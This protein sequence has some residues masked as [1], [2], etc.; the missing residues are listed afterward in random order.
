M[1]DAQLEFHWLRAI[2]KRGK[3]GLPE[4][5]GEGDVPQ[6]VRSFGVS[7]CSRLPSPLFSI[8]ASTPHAELPAG[9]LEPQAVHQKCDFLVVASDFHTT[10]TEPELVWN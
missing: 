6:G 5:H 7:F 8:W 10:I 2:T 9:S 3:P 1:L 4:G